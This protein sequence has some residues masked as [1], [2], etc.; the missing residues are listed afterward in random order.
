MAVIKKT[1]G[2]YIPPPKGQHPVERLG[3]PPGMMVHKGN[4]TT[5]KYET[6]EQPFIRPKTVLGRGRI[7]RY[8]ASTKTPE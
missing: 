8:D 7:I 1:V 5:I 3:N 4:Y 2:A 6:S